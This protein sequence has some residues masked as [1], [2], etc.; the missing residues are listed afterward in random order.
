[1]MDVF[2][3]KNQVR[4]LPKEMEDAFQNEKISILF[5][6]CLYLTNSIAKSRDYF[7]YKVELRFI[8]REIINFLL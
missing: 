7:S 5:L 8:W 1:M 2:Q 4:Y 6:I 3:F